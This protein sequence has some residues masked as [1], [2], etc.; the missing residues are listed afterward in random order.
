MNHGTPLVLVASVSPY[1][2][3]S[4]QSSLKRT[5][6]TTV[7][8]DNAEDAVR[9]LAANGVSCVLVIDSGL[10]E[11]AHDAQWRHLRARHSTLGAVV[12]CL[13]PRANGSQRTDGYTL[14]VRPDDRKAL[15]QAVRAL[16]ATQNRL[17]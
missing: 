6:F 13:V 8:V 4:V 11:A 14:L 17:D 12:R 9:E 10:L 5:G 1:E 3:R 16:A 2:R 15:R 7:A